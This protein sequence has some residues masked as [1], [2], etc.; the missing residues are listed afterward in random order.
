MNPPM[1]TE[2]PKCGHVLSIPLPESAACPV[3]GIYF[4]KYTQHQ[5]EPSSD[6]PIES[7]SFNLRELFETLL[8]PLDDIGVPTFYGRC[9][10]LGLLAL[11]GC[12]LFADDY[13][14]GE[15]GSSFMHNIL[16]PIH[17]AGHVLFTPLGTFM[18]VLGGSLFQLVLP[19]G[20][21]IAFIWINRD[22]VAA[23]VAMWWA[24]ASFLDLAPYVYDARH[25]RLILLGGHTGEDGPHDWVY[26]LTALG[27]LQDSQQWGA[28]VHT[29]GGILMLLAISWALSVLWRQRLVIPKNSSDAR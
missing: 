13:R 29:L 1:H 9:L 3:C 6:T 20:M 23:A 11:W 15:I 4:F 10:V 22:N 21:S 12:F 16:L 18:T 25:P 28:A 5:S 8:A 17:E 19:L 26:L 24:G 27:Q 2:C 14:V 7:S